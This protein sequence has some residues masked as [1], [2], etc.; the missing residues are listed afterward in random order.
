MDKVQIEVCREG[1]KR[2]GLG[3]GIGVRRREGGQRGG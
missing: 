3:W 1:G 2:G